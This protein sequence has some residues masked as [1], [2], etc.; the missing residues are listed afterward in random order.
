MFAPWEFHPRILR[1]AGKL[2]QPGPMLLCF[3]EKH[4]DLAGLLSTVEDLVD[5]HFYEEHRYQAFARSLEVWTDFRF[6]HNE[7]RMEKRETELAKHGK[8]EEYYMAEYKK[9][10]QGKMDVK[11]PRELM[12]YFGISKTRDRRQGADRAQHLRDEAQ[13]EVLRRAIE[14]FTLS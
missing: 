2:N 4:P 12:W 10:I 13:V 5:D 11:R 3:L 1:V 9:R 7:N 8:Y 14:N 6:Q